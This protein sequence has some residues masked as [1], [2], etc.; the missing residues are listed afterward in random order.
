MGAVVVFCEASDDGK[1]K[2]N[3]FSDPDGNVI[4]LSEEH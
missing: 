4:G 1:T 2:L 3:W